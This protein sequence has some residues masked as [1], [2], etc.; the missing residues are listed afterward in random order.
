MRG[1]DLVVAIGANQKQVRD[2][3]LGE[4]ILEQI[5]SSRVEPLQVVEKQRERMFRAREDADETP[6]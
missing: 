2:A 5:Q 1:I 6:Q 3:L 4:E